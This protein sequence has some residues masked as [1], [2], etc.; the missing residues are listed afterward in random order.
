M[1]IQ[2]IMSHPIVTCPVDSTLHHAA[3][4]MWEYDCGIIPIVGDDGRLVGVV[5]DRDACMAAYTQGRPLSEIPIATAMAKDVVASHTSDTL[6]AVESLM[7]A[8]QVRRVPVVDGEYRPVGL[9]S[10]NDL[11]RLA[12][13]AHRNGVDRQVVE[14]LAAVSQPRGNAEPAARDSA[15]GVKAAEDRVAV[16]V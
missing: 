3:R 1:R 13:R 5:T 4:L 12:A 7:K 16:V 14:T 8:S 2:E 6:E 9:V 10:I 11:A 15:G